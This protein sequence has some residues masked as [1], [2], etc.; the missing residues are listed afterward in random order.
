MTTA[1][2]REACT[3]LVQLYEKS[4]Q[5]EKATA[6]KEKLDNDERLTPKTG[7]GTFNR[8]PRAPIGKA[9]WIHQESHHRSVRR[10]ARCGRDA[11]KHRRG[12]IQRGCWPAAHPAAASGGRDRELAD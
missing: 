12:A 3:Q 9:M 2:A 5:P 10:D 8:Y 6:W 1:Q 7:H 11:R 4:N